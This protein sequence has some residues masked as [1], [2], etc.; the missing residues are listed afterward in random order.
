MKYRT[1][2]CDWFPG[3]LNKVVV[4]AK[5]QTALLWKMLFPGADHSCSHV[6]I[7]DASLSL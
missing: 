5:R 4:F 2:V 3:K 1:G 7:P 6:E